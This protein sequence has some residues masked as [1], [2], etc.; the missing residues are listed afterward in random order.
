MKYQYGFT[1]IELLVTIGVLVFIGSGGYGAYR[2]FIRRELL[3][4]TYQEL[5]TNLS[6]TRQRALS[7]VRPSG[8]GATDS[9][10]AYEV[11]FTVSSYTTSAICGG[12]TIGDR[13]YILPDGIRFTTTRPTSIRYKI[14]GEGAQIS[15]SSSVVLESIATQETKTVNFTPEGLIQ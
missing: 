15:G 14:I 10:L 7:G 12:S 8:C 3:E 6:L 5:K 2:E 4:G 9:L 11:T 1:L 13:S